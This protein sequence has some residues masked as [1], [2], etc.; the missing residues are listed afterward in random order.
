MDI[1]IAANIWSYISQAFIC[2]VYDIT[3][4]SKLQFCCSVIT[5]GTSW[6]QKYGLQ[7]I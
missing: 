5:L 2:F 1:N 3:C 4:Y 6:V 7:K